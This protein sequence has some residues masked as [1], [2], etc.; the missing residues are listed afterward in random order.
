MF[1]VK[2]CANCG[3]NLFQL[4]FDVHPSLACA[5][6]G[7]VYNHTVFKRLPD[8]IEAGQNIKISVTPSTKG[9]VLLS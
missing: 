2:K 8:D 6:C 9:M 4:L 1:R 7:Q 3:H 5:S